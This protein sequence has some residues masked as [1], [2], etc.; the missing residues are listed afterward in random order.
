MPADLPVGTKGLLTHETADGNTTL[1]FTDRYILCFIDR[2]IVRLLQCAY[3]C[4][5]LHGVWRAHARGIGLAGH[6]LWHEPQ[7]LRGRL[8]TRKHT[9]SIY[10]THTGHTRPYSKRADRTG[11]EPAG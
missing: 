5:G 9:T 1:C 8:H 11:Q 6:T 2:Y 7:G 3:H 10:Y 4:A